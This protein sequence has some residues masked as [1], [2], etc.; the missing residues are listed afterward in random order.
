MSY[1]KEDED[2]MLC[3]KIECQQ[4]IADLYKFV[5]VI[6]IFEPNSNDTCKK[7]LTA[8][9]LLLRGATLKNTEFVY[10]KII[11]IVSSKFNTF[12]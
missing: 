5:G 12:E 4:P 8:E 10:G 1:I 11:L 3:A 6:D 2:L 9:N 7:P